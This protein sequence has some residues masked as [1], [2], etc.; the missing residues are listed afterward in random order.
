MR[1]GGRVNG[2]RWTYL[3]D[4]TMLVKTTSSGCAGK[5]RREERETGGEKN[6]KKILFRIRDRQKTA[7][8]M[9]MAHVRRLDIA[10]ST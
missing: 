6:Q 8:A 3:D 5:L 9:A 2:E 4:A 7:M 1:R 10:N